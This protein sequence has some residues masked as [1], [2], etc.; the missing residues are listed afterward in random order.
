MTQRWATSSSN[1]QGEQSSLRPAAETVVASLAKEALRVV[2]TQ[3]AAAADAWDVLAAMAAARPLHA[4]VTVLLRGVEAAQCTLSSDGLEPV[5]AL[6]CARY[7]DA[8]LAV[9]NPYT[10]QVM[11]QQRLPD[12]LRSQCTKSGCQELRVVATRLRDAL[13]GLR[14]DDR[15][16]P[17]CRPSFAKGALSL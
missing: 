5:T 13:R 12:A 1:A 7:V 11:R 15:S 2:R 17:R 10:L 9:P 16:V 8:L 14:V 3:P 6:A 4:A